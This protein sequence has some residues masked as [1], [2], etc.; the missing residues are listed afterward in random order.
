MAKI[1]VD[2]AAPSLVCCCAQL[3]QVYISQDGGQAWT[4]TQ[5]PVELSRSR[6]IYPM[7]CG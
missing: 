2:R 6:H 3:G 1:A 7:V 4:Q 5:V